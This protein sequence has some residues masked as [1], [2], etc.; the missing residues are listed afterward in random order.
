MSKINVKKG[1]DQAPKDLVE[2]ILKGQTLPFVVALTHKA[3]KGLVIP[4]SGISDV[5]KADTETKVKIR[6]EDQA[7]LLVTDLA[8][9]ARLAGSDDKEFAT[10]EIPVPAK[11]KKAADAEGG[12]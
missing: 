5:I 12:E 4:S 10:I 7:W 6:S 8:T 3:R 2:K 9:F 11:P 1:D